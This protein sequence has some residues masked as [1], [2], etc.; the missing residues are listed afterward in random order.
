ML[1][2]NLI[3]LGTIEMI[4]EKNL[5]PLERLFFGREASSLPQRDQVEAAERAVELAQ[6][7][8]HPRVG[9]DCSTHPRWE[10]MH[11][12]CRIVS[13][14]FANVQSKNQVRILDVGTNLGFIPLQLSREF[15][16]VVGVDVSAELITTCRVAALDAG[17]RARFARWD[18]FASMKKNE[19]LD[20]YNVDCLILLNVLHQVIFKYGLE[21]VQI[22]LAEVITKVDY[23][24]VEL[25]ERSEYKS[26]EN[27]HLLPHNSSDVFAMCS[28]CE[29]TRLTP[30]FP[31]KNRTLYLV[32]RRK[33]N[34]GNAQLSIR[35][36]A[37]SANVAAEIARKYYFCDGIVVKE[38]RGLRGREAERF[39]SE[40]W[41]LDQI[42]RRQEFPHL[43]LVDRKKQLGRVV[44]SR[45]SGVLLSDLIQFDLPLNARKGIVQQLS[46]ILLDL[47]DIGIFQ[48]DLSAHNL[49]VDARGVLQLFDFDRAGSY[50]TMEPF[51]AV[52]W[53]MH[54]VIV[55]SNVSY[56][57]EVFDKLSFFDT[58]RTISRF[59]PPKEPF[60]SDPLFKEIYQSAI[61]SRSYDE[62]LQTLSAVTKRLPPNL[63]DFDVLQVCIAQA[64]Q[65][66]ADS[67]E[68]SGWFP[69]SH[70][71]AEA[72]AS[73]VFKAVM[74]RAPSDAVVAWLGAGAGEPAD[75]LEKLCREAEGRSRLLR[76]LDRT[77]QSSSPASSGSGAFLQIFDNNYATLLGKRAHTFRLMFERLLQK[78]PEG[79]LI[80]E[81]GALRA[82][83]NWEGDGQST[84]LFGKFCGEHSGVCI[85]ID[86]SLLAMD[87]SQRL[88][89]DCS[90][91]I[92]GESLKS[93]QNMRKIAEGKVIDLLYLDSFDVDFEDASPSAEHHLSELKAVWPLLGKGSI[94]AVDDTPI[95]EGGVIGKGQFV[96]R[97]LTDKGA[98][99]IGSG[100]QS[101]WE[102]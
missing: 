35:R 96:E 91:R 57:E 78:R 72:T 86:S 40:V 19:E 21:F 38:Y 87:S 80:V 25:A 17:S 61:T 50:P 32:E 45:C 101:V 98:K 31:Y 8:Y 43:L 56:M 99:K 34:V 41:S 1:G 67:Q 70:E 9:L 12:R 6:G 79:H 28:G 13:S 93:L 11:E 75:V 30:Q 102:I 53:L 33:L 71:S 18:L 89:E 44:M 64:G 47:N 94:V 23:L 60:G 22:S 65:I 3:S 77:Q 27:G 92:Y 15:P 88:S 100:Y 49:I 90:V 2:Q 39:D 4:D 36:R 54:D 42:Q 59:L 74:G 24:L 81:T 48:N 52:L 68:K 46:R 95:T 58:D 73:T 82:I 55:G 26:H 14:L 85:S 66:E 62:F 83:G 7:S 10:M 37:F 84:Y 69:P 16:T 97:Y 20:L 29:I 51:G 76:A 63:I 5:L